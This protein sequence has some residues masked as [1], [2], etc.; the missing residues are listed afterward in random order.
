MAGRC[1]GKRSMWEV[2]RVIGNVGYLPDANLTRELHVGE[3]AGGARPPAGAGL[4]RARDEELRR[5]SNF[6]LKRGFEQVKE[7]MGLIGRR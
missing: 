6:L 3:F 2:D 1:N 7:V 5:D 4:L